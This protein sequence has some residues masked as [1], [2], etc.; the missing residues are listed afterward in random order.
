MRVVLPAPLGPSS[1]KNSP[2]SMSRADL[3]QCLEGAFGAWTK[4]LET[5]WNET[6][7]M[8][9]LILGLGCTPPPCAQQHAGVRGH[10]GRTVRSVAAC[11]KAST[12]YRPAM[13]TSAGGRPLTTNALPAASASR[14]HS[15][16]TAS[17]DVSNTAAVRWHPPPPGALENLQPLHQHAQAGTGLAWVSSEGSTSMRDVSLSALGGIALVAGRQRLD[18]AI[19]AAALIS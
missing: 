13:P 6:A 18:Q 15:S 5:A 12:P 10:C 3:V 11:S 9:P 17:A 14:R 8:K 7:G 4:V 16:S 19:H 1:P 2:S